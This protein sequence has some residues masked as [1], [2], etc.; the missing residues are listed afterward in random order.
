[1]KLVNLTCPNCA[2]PLERQGDNLY[3]QVCGGAFAI[4]YDDADVEHEKMMTEEERAR[5]H[6]ELEEERKKREFE[7]QKELMEIKFRQ[8]QEARIAA[9]QRQIKRARKE[10][11]SRAV[12]ARISGL[13]ALAV[14][15]AFFYGSYRLMVASGAVP[16]I[17]DIVESAAS[18]VQDPHDVKPEDITDDVL[19]GMIDA[20]HTTKVNTRGTNGV[21]D[22][23][24]NEWIDYSL[25][26][27]EYD[28]AYYIS[29]A[30]TGYNRVVIIFRLNY[31]SSIGDKVTYDASYFDNLQ[32]DVNGNLITDYNPEHISRGN[33]AWHGDSYLDFDQC[34]RENVQAFGGT[35]TELTRGGQT[36][37]ESDVTANESVAEG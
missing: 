2:G 30:N 12:R 36:V 22:L 13:I 4:D 33:A 23:V 3:C 11:F 34:Y 32:L 19:E 25:V 37:N 28:S 16:K 9:E 7:H 35:V 27:I 1:M 5:R 10:R 21:T 31:T 29:G 18:R 24:N 17:K 26:S 6:F 14:I 20:A 8:E 15:A